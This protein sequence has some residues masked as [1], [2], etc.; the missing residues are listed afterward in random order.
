M[1]SPSLADNALRLFLTLLTLLLAGSVLEVIRHPLEEA[2]LPD[3]SGAY[4]YDQAPALAPPSQGRHAAPPP[5]LP[6]TGG[7]TAGTGGPPWDPAP[8]PPDLDQYHRQAR[9]RTGPR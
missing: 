1:L 9:H 5:A 8:K 2:V 3:E 4:R 7:P 6:D